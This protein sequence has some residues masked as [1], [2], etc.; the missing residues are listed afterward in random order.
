MGY[1]WHKMCIHVLLSFWCYFFI[2]CFLKNYL[3]LF[4]F[5]NNSLSSPSLPPLPKMKQKLVRLPMIY[6]N[7]LKFS[8]SG[9]NWTDLC[10][11]LTASWHLWL[12]MLHVAWEQLVPWKQ[13]RRHTSWKGFNSPQSPAA[14]SWN[15]VSWKGLT[16]IMD[17]SCC[18]GQPQESHY[19][20]GCV[21]QTLL[22]LYGI[23]KPSSSSHC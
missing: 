23:T 5:I 1:Y 15:K 4:I 12:V 21:V 11:L 3:M 19:A 9:L 20:S 17:S 22:E 2:F 14:E 10:F 7:H 13:C 16:R 18:A 6:E 8:K